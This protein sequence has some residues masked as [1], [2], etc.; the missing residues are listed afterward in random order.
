MWVCFQPSRQARHYSVLVVP[1]LHEELLL[2]TTRGSEG[3]EPSQS[4]LDPSLPAHR[5]PR[6]GSKPTES[7]DTEKLL[8]TIGHLARESLASLPV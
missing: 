2:A 5:V 4:P 1:R 6:P 8:F 7:P 3:K